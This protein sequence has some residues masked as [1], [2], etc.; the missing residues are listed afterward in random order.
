MKGGIRGGKWKGGTGEVSE[1]RDEGRRVKGDEGSGRGMR[2]RVV[3][4]GGGEDEWR[5]VEGG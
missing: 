5:G 3:E 2:G 1:R 4:R